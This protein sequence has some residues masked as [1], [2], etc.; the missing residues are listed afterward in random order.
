MRHPSGNRWVV[1]NKAKRTSK[2]FDIRRHLVLSK[3]STH[4]MEDIAEL[5]AK[6]IRK[7]W[8]A[9]GGTQLRAG[10]PVT[11]EKENE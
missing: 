1:L 6:L 4:L 7:L 11:Q 9:V 2:L 3:K 10:K 8:V 5:P